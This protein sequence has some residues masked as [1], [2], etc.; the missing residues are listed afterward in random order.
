MKQFFKMFFAS[1]LAM[2]VLGVIIFALIVGV[3]AGLASSSKDDE[4]KIADNSVLVIDMDKTIH[5]L[6]EENPFAVFGGNNSYSPGLYAIINS[7]KNA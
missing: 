2:V 3:I 1:F 5:E 7:I 6:G 4:H